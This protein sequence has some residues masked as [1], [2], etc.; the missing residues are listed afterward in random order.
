MLRDAL[1]DGKVTRNVA[2]SDFVDTPTPAPRP[3]TVI[4]PA[5]RQKLLDAVREDRLG[6]LYVVAFATGA[7]LGELTGLR[8]RDVEWDGGSSGHGQV[9]IVQTVGRVGRETVF[10]KPKNDSS[11][12]TFPMNATIRAALLDQKRRQEWGLTG[13]PPKAL[14]GHGPLVFTATDGGPLTGSYVTQ[15]LQKLLAGAGLPRIR[16]HDA[17]HSFVSWAADAG[18][19]VDTISKLVGHSSTA[20][21]RSVYLHVFEEKKADAVAA[22]QS[23]GMTVT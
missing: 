9:Q 17:R 10:G 18:I 16:F 1:R 3:Q 20:V 15:H 19:D 11:S 14:G 12:R 21:T 7:R 22:L 5:D 13:D 23:P 8:W 6:P 2:T 4:L